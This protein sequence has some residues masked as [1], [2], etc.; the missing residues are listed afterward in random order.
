MG[1]KKLKIIISLESSMEVGAQGKHPGVKTVFIAFFI[2]VLG[3]TQFNMVSWHAPIIEAVI[4]EPGRLISN[5][6][7]F[8]TVLE[9]RGLE[10]GSCLVCE[11]LELDFS[12]CPHGR[13]RQGALFRLS[14]LF[15]RM[16]PSPKALPSNTVTLGIRI[17][18]K[19]FCWGRGVTSIQTIAPS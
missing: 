16:E 5:R 15:I 17:S 3:R 6:S 18:T 2:N 1:L 4:P 12:L 14:F 13:R 8:L 11:G 19:E 10:S 9:G 7:F